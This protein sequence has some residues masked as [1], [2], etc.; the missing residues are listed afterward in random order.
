VSS[1]DYYDILGVAKNATEAEIKKAYRAKA[2][3]FHPDRNPG[4]KTAEANFKKIQEAY[5]ILGNREKRA[6]YDEFGKAGVGHV[7]DFN[8][9]KVYTW[10][11]GSKISLDELDELFTA[12]GGGRRTSGTTGTGFFDQIF[13]QSAGTSRS[14]R[15]RRTAAH[16]PRRG[17]DIEKTVH[18]SFDQAVRGASV[19]IRLVNRNGSGTGQTLSVRIPPN[20][21]PDQRIRLAGKGQ[22]GPSGGPPGDLIIVCHVAP[23]PWFERHGRDIHLTVPI[24]ISE[25]ALGAKVDVPTLDGTVTLSIPPGTSSGAKLRLK[26]RGAREKPGRTGDQIVTI[27]IV[28]PK[29]ISAQA[30]ESLQKAHEQLEFDPRAEVPWQGAC[31][32]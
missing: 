26:E 31:E 29:H 28:A 7:E 27:Q 12:F 2:K 16:R 19:D 1:E 13:G 14:R 8:G 5:D 32:S 4:D 23:H 9:Q 18:L 3:Q 30:K 6:K 17:A 25:A 22:P 11:G 24:S 15:T 10:P 20:V 21:Q